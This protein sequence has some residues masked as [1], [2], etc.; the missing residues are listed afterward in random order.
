MALALKSFML[1]QQLSLYIDVF[2]KF[3]IICWLLRNMNLSMK[4][5]RRDCSSNA[6]AYAYALHSNMSE[7]TNK[8]EN[9]S[10]HTMP[11]GI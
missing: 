7:L 10:K 2:L 9:W 8:R 3:E 5:H 11:C 1:N 6:Y 4:Y